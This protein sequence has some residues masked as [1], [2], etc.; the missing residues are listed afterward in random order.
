GQ[1]VINRA[2]RSYEIFYINGRYIRSSLIGKAVE[3]GYREYLMQ[4]KFPFCVLHIAMDTSR[5]DVNVH[6]TKMDVRFTNA[7]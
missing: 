4:H 1:P 3:E 7:M 2:N 6:P 5:V